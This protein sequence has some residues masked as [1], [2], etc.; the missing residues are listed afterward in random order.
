MKGNIMKLSKKNLLDLHIACR[1]L[2]E[3]ALLAYTLYDIKDAAT[4]YY[5]KNTERHLDVLI[6]ILENICEDEAARTKQI[7]A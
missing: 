1:T 4:D 5:T 2:H 7:D 6:R 3:D